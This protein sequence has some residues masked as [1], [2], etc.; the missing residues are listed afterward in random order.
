MNQRSALRIVY[1]L[2]VG[3]L[4]LAAVQPFGTDAYAQPSYFEH[5]GDDWLMIVIGVGVLGCL[6]WLGLKI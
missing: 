1:W 4:I 6:I 3:G 2:F 5:Y